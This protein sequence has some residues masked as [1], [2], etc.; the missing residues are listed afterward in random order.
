MDNKPGL[1]ASQEVFRLIDFIASCKQLQAFHGYLTS[2]TRVRDLWTKTSRRTVWHTFVN[3]TSTP[4]SEQWHSRTT[5]W[6][7]ET[8]YQI[9]SPCIQTPWS[10]LE[11]CNEICSRDVA[12]QGSWFP[13]E[14]SSLRR[15]GGKKQAKS[16]HNKG[17]VGRLISIGPWG[18]GTCVLI[19]KGTDA[20]DPE[21]VHGLQ[22]K[23]VAV[24]CLRL[25]KPRVIP[26]GWSKHAITTLAHQ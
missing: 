25:S 7:S 16:A 10:L 26:D 24:D 8:M 12:S 6:L 13:I 21:L 22:P 2:A 17:A 11:L 3:F 1:V 19:A 20:Q 5:S 14:C 9:P 18:N 15:R 23:T 4:A